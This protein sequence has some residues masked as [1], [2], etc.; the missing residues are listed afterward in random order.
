MGWLPTW[1]GGSAPAQPEPVRKKSSDGGYVA[2]DRNARDLCYESR[3]LFFECL[4]KN[5][6]L[7]AVKEDEKARKVCPTEY[8][9]FERDCAKTWIKYF[10]EKRVMEYN[11]DMTIA[12]IKAEDDAV[13]A[14]LK[15]E[16][17]ARGAWF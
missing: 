4:D 6:I 7:S 3:D 14:K 13:V 8:A 16:R 9:E 5:D 12:K 2:P 11:R 17:K 10:K 15:A 1:L